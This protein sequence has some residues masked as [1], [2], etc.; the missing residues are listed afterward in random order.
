MKKLTQAKSQTASSTKN[1][2]YSKA[3]TTLTCPGCEKQATYKIGEFNNDDWVKHRGK[4]WCADCASKWH[5]VYIPSFHPAHAVAE[6][7]VEAEEK[8][9]IN[10]LM[11]ML[12]D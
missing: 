11:E 6:K 2:T 10:Q 12:D 4:W 1:Q 8:A 5:P 9:D 3:G 7:R